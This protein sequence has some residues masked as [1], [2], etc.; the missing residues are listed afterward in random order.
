ML[1]I[2]LYIEGTILGGIGRGGTAL[3]PPR[4]SVT[5]SE[6]RNA[7][8]AAQGDKVEFR[9]VELT[10]PDGALLSAWFMRPPEPNGDAVI[11]LHG[12]SDNRMGMY[13]YGKWLV[14]NPYLVLL[15]DPLLPVINTRPLAT[16]PFKEPDPLFTL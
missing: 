16:S 5:A 15:P 2:A 13:G 14:Q 10:S 7:R 6:E 9:D 4:H 12:V 1:V 11:L 3:P 8:A